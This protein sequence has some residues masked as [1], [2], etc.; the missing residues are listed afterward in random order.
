ME[1]LSRPYERPKPKL[2]EAF[3]EHEVMASETKT[4]QH[5]GL[6]L[7]MQGHRAGQVSAFPTRTASFTAMAT[8]NAMQNFP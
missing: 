3:V 5:A 4:Q 2:H 8:S 1:A 7:R 6:H